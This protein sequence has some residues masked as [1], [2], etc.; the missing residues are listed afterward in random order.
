MYC[1][2]IH[3]LSIHVYIGMERQLKGLTVQSFWTRGLQDKRSEQSGRRRG[4]ARTLVHLLVVETL[5]GAVYWPCMQTRCEC[6]WDDGHAPPSLH[7][8]V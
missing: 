3:G 1:S 6:R 7:L 5:T 2:R 8:H 4:G